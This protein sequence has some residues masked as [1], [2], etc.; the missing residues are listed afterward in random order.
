MAH[1]PLEALARAWQTTMLATMLLA[2]ALALLQL[3]DSVQLWNNAV[4]LRAAP[5]AFGFGEYG[6]L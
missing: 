3:W 5:Q 1:I 4:H 6:E 2:T